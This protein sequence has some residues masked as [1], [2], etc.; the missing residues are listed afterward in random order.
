MKLQEYN[1]RVIALGKELFGDNYHFSSTTIDSTNY[2]HEEKTE[3]KY[4]GT[5]FLRTPIGGYGSITGSS[6]DVEVVF[7]ELRIEYRK[8]MAKP[9]TNMEL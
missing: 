3:T 9:S 6:A 5:I 1:E 4:R 7:D 2:G 8:M